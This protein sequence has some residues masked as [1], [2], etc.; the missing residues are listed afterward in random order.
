MGRAH[1]SLLKRTGSVSRYVILKSGKSESG[2]LERFLVET[3]PHVRAGDE[4][5]FN[6]KCVVFHI[7]EHFCELQ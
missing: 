1:I 3:F 6:P 5:Y 2:K 7:L 4:R